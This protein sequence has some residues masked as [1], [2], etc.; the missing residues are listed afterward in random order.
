MLLVQGLYEEAE[1]V[2][3]RLANVVVGLLP[4]RKPAPPMTW[5]FRDVVR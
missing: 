3:Y 5:Y 4:T 2:R 1:H